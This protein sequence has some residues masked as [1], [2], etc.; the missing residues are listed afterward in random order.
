M[1][2]AFSF[3][4]IVMVFKELETLTFFTGTIG[5]GF[6]LIALTVPK[7]LQDVHARW[8]KFADFIGQFNTKIIIGFVYLVFFSLMRLFFLIIQKDPMN[9]KFIPSASSYWQKHETQEKED[10]TRRYEK[11]Y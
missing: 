2:G 7:K 1:G 4:T 9:R 11:Q 8:M 6:I 3:I 5:L 10:A